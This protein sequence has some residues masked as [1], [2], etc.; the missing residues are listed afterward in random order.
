MAIEY[1]KR[2]PDACK[3][4]AQESGT[5]LKQVWC[6]NS[7]SDSVA[8]PCAGVSLAL[9]LVYIDDFERFGHILCSL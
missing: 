3:T 9:I 1:K 8:I 6:R 7:W 4:W 2:F 5:S